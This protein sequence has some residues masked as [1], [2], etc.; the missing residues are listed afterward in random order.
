[1][2]ETAGCSILR[3]R[4]KNLFQTYEKYLDVSLKEDSDPTLLKENVNR[5]NVK[6]NDD[7]HMLHGWQESSMDLGFSP[8]FCGMKK[9]ISYEADCDF[10]RNSDKTNETESIFNNDSY[11]KC[12][13]R[14]SLVKE[15]LLVESYTSII[16]E[17]C[18]DKINVCI[19]NKGLPE[20]II[21]AQIKGKNSFLIRCNYFKNL[22]SFFA[23]QLEIG[24]YTLTFFLNKEL[25]CVNL[26]TDSIDT[27]KQYKSLPLH[28]I[29]INDFGSSVN[30]RTTGSISKKKR[31]E[32]KKANNIHTNKELLKIYNSICKEYGNKE[33]G[34]NS[35]LMIGYN[36]KLR[37]TDDINF[38]SLFKS[39]NDQFV[40]H[41]FPNNYKKE[42]DSDYANN[43]NTINNINFSGPLNF[44][45]LV[46]QNRIPIMYKKLLYDNCIYENKK[47]LMQ[48]HTNLFELD[49]FE[50]LSVHIFTKEN[51]K[52]GYSIF[53][54]NLI[55]LAKDAKQLGVNEAFLDAS[56]LLTR[57]E[58]D[59]ITD[60]DVFKERRA[61]AN[62]DDLVSIDRKN[63]NINKNS[64]F[65]ITDKAKDYKSSLYMLQSDETNC[66]D[67]RLWKHLDTFTCR[68]NKRATDFY[69]KKKECCTNIQS[70]V[71]P[72]LINNKN[73]FKK[74]AEGIKISDN[75]SI[76][77]EQWNEDV[78]PIKKF[79]D[80]FNAEK[81]LKKIQR[82]CSLIK[83]VKA[84]Y[85]LFDEY[86]NNMCFDNALNKGNNEANNNDSNKYNNL[87]YNNMQKQEQ[88]NV[89]NSDRKTEQTTEKGNGEGKGNDKNILQKKIMDHLQN[90]FVSFTLVVDGK[91]YNSVVPISKFLLVFIINCWLYF[92]DVR[93]KLV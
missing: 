84:D 30:S 40:N 60:T 46:E 14:F 91:I 41:T 9:S 1:M 81:P 86:F 64:N 19:A 62:I 20:G 51:L 87:T 59:G 69:I 61:I 53:A 37:N 44:E 67:I 23:P 2:G 55:P 31:F 42:K 82:V 92:V 66:A 93:K 39:Y 88:G 43:R 70:P 3:N 16:Y 85:L 32:L 78:M 25:L 77:F 17:N 15:C 49:P 34:R 73:V 90:N 71:P 76:F 79:I 22:I 57:D 35:Q 72:E 6:G 54:F 10:F 21:E 7:H 48:F 63:K 36:Y 11:N 28:V 27:E 26:L 65:N 29:A 68:K 24:V 74:Y 13:S 80:P 52:D 5:L 18:E 47:I 33:N 50:V 83:D 58:I 45:P 8:D 56:K 75:V 4:I 38:Y 12:I 89:D